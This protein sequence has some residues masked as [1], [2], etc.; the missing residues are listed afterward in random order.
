MATYP[1]GNESTMQLEPRRHARCTP[2]GGGEQ[3][4]AFVD[5]GLQVRKSL[6]FLCADTLVGIECLSNFRDHASEFV[7][8]LAEKTREACQG[9]CHRLAAGNAGKHGHKLVIVERHRHDTYVIVET[10]AAISSLLI[11]PARTFSTSV[12]T[13]SSRE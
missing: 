9:R 11:S 7:G 4:Q 1:F 2:R 6:S 13:K 8:V 12:L 3:S 5:D 10:W